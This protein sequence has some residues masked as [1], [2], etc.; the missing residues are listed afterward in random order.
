MSN[1]TNFTTV[2]LACQHCSATNPN[3]EFIELMDKIQELRDVVGFSLPITSG[4]RC[5]DHPI[6]AR[7]ASPG[8]HTSAAVDVGVYGER[9]YTVLRE[10]L[11]LGFTGVGVRQKGMKRFIHLDLRD[12]PTVWSY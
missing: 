8:H 9:A 2:E 12:I 3:P 7:K 10:A 1:W 11:R 4:Y 5:P 6:E